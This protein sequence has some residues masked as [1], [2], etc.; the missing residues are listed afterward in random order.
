M[1]DSMSFDF[2][3]HDFD[4]N[5]SKG[6]SSEAFVKQ[7]SQIF[8]PNRLNHHPPY[9]FNDTSCCSLVGPCLKNI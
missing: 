5:F 8:E 6:L 2:F 3:K 9:S 7:T 1:I 4:M